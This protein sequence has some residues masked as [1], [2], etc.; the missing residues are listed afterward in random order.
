MTQHR[1]ISDAATAE[2]SNV[3]PG[4]ARATDPAERRGIAIASLGRAALRGTD[5]SGLFRAATDALADELDVDYVKVLELLPEEGMLVV[6]AGRGWEDGIVGRARVPD[7]EDSQAGYTLRCRQAV[8]V[9]DLPGETRFHGPGL[10]L[11]H[12]VLSG[13]SMIIGSER[14]PWGVLGVHSRRHVEFSAAD[15][16][17]LETVAYVLTEAIQRREA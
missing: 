13:M 5:L 7:G 2:P 6:V 16:R 10:L 4:Q 11:D 9:A 1:I 14:N 15:I 17:F 3:D 8:V 12:G